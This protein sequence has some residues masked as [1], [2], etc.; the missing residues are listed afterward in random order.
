MT[1]AFGSF[2]P[3]GSRFD[4]SPFDSSSLFQ[5]SKMS[6]FSPNLATVD[7][8][9]LEIKGKHLRTTTTKA[10]VF[11]LLCFLSALR[12]GNKMTIVSSRTADFELRIARSTPCV[13]E[14]LLGQKPRIF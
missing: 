10:G 3:I 9:L 13:D 2:F 11:C 5:P 7:M 14:A 1:R 8:I 6:Y 12:P 4:P